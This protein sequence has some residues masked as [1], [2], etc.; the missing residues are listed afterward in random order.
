MK[1]IVMGIA[2]LACAASM[3]AVD[4]AATVKVRGDV[5]LGKNEDGTNSIS[6]FDMENTNQK[7]ADLLRVAFTGDK[8]GANFEFWTTAKEAELKVRRL[9]VWFTPIDGL[10]ITAGN[11]DL[12]LYTERLD[13]WKVPCGASVA[14]FNSWDGRWASGAGVHESFGVTAE[15]TAIQNLYIGIGASSSVFSKT[16]SADAAIN[17]WGAV[18]KYQ[19]LDNVSAGAAFRYTTTFGLLTAGADFGSYNT[20]YYGFVQAK[21]RFDGNSGANTTQTFKDWKLAG[22]T[23]DNYIAYNFGNGI[24]IEGTFP[25]TIRGFLDADDKTDVSYMTARAKVTVPVDAFNIYA[26]VGSDEGLLYVDNRPGENK[27]SA[28]ALVWKFKNFGEN[29][30]FYGNVG[31]TFN[32]GTCAVNIGL[33][34]AYDVPA[35]TFAWAIPFS[36]QVAF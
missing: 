25:V 9:K 24:K 10:K 32:V 19:I 20:P 27:K 21:I 12:T 15:F 28:E 18:A 34:A 3:F 31:A 5:I 8:A 6:V 17:Q 4:F 14:E 16:G 13:Y 35:K 30:N 23:I 29:F 33:E 11:S 36:A 7:D 26:V 1:K 22:I 2:A